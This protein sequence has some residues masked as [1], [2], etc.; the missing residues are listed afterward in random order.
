MGHLNG[1]SP[2]FKWDKLAL[3]KPDQFDDLDEHPVV[4]G[5]GHDLEE[6]R[7]EG[8]VVA[9]VLASQFT[10]HAHGGRL[11]TCTTITEYTHHTT[12]PSHIIAYT[13]TNYTHHT[14][15]LITH[16]RNHRLHSSHNTLITHHSIHITEITEHTHHTTH[17]ITHH[18]M[19]ITEITEHTPHTTHHARLPL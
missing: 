13:F 4:G 3:A 19:H 8:E 10:D 14:T 18:S 7:S 17:L 1:P 6:G 12:P 9:R 15:H 11:D 2:G 16:H 5:G